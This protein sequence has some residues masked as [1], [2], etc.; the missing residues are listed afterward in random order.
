MLEVKGLTCGYNERFLLQDINFKVRKGEF[1]GIIGPN[2]SGKTTL[3]RAITKVLRS[4]KGEIILD[5][6]NINYYGFRELA[7]KIAV[8]SQDV[9]SFALNLT[10]KEYVLLGRIPFRRRFQFLETRQDKEITHETLAITGILNLAQ[11]PV[12]EMSGGERQCAIIARALAQEPQLLLLDEPT[13]HLDIGHQIK[14]LDLIR[15]LNKERG[16]T[17]IIILHDLNLASEYCERLL[18]LKEGKIY[19]IGDPKEVLTYPIIEEVYGTLVVVGKSPVSSKPLVCLVPEDIRKAK[20]QYSPVFFEL[21][22]P[23]L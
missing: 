10:V 15:K 23:S 6:K 12:A 20:P 19:R 8:V 11:R 18:L 2:G 9:D 13:T 16:L 4:K 14:I 22:K 17:V 1:L 7:Q 3:I 5:G 21:Q